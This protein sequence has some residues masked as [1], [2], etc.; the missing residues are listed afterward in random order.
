MSS[1]NLLQREIRRYIYDEG[2][3][4]LRGIQEASIKRISNTDHNLILAAPTASGKTEA[5]FLPAI[6]SIKDWNSGLKIIY[7]S[8]LIALINDQFKRILKLCDYIDIPVISWHGEAS[9]TDKNKLLKQPRGILLITPESI[10]AMLALRPGEAKELFKGTEWIIVDEIHGFLEN[11]RGV[12]LRSLIE[13]IKVYMEKDPRFIGMSA[14]LNREDYK[15][16]KNFFIS[17]RVTDV[18]L[19]S[20]KN[21]LEATKSYYE[22]NIKKD[23]KEALEEIYDYSQRES[24]LVFPNSRGEVE[25]LAVGLSRLG[26]KRGSDT[27]YFAHHS[28]VS[29]DMRLTA[30]K[31]AKGSKGELF[32]IC[33][34]STL[35]LGIDIGSVDSIVQ[36]NAP[37]SVAS[38]G[39]RLGRSGRTTRENIL[40]FIATDEWSLLQGLAA[41]SLYE[42]GVID[43]FDPIIKPYDVFAHQIISIL[44]ENTGMPFEDVKDINKN[45]KCWHSIEDDEYL[46]LLGY[47]IERNYIELLE[48][49]AIA[50]LETE[51]L[52]K[53]S[54]FF[55]HFETENN[56]S[57]YNDYKK[58]G[59]IP[60]SPSVQIGENIFLSAQIWKI[61]DIELVSKK[62]Y[63]T[64]AVDGNPPMFSG[65]SGNITNEIRSRMKT[66]LEDR[67]YW[68]DYSD[69]IKKVLL[70]LSKENLRY[71]K[72]QWTEENDKIGLRTFQSTK[73]NRTLQLLLNM[74]GKGENYK[75]DDRTTFIS[76]CNIKEDI[77]R[78]IERSFNE[79]E[80]FRYLKDS[81]QIV[82]LYLS[83]NKYRNLLPD[84]LKIKYIIKNKLG[85]EG[86]KAYLGIL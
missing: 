8:P 7:I 10:E 46:E 71:E 1:F 52:L 11:N 32:T 68:I 54:D 17:D 39:Q 60:L 72:F 6:N 62:I 78:V 4:N 22:S 50:G 26:K 31:F 56:F 15:E 49:E 61:K 65:G 82:E 33:C 81:P 3:D 30:E 86:T 14:T 12:Q 23:S 67:S 24:M 45:F 59:E 48:T 77:N 64:R 63:V 19:D 74:L 42:D 28:S 79:E 34:T 2:W 16:V 18:L 38:L 70:K 9:R 37:H 55:A 5:A 76:G 36:Y 69:N 53:G 29:K 51:R 58:I 21:S 57:L 83:S 40:H 66:I 43:R 25:R 85:L 80:I 41:I 20:N 47:L 27:R 13:R 75:L 44:L 35:E 84:D 73:I